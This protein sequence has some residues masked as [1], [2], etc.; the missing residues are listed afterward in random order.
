M[1]VKISRAKERLMKGVKIGEMKRGKYV[2][3]EESKREREGET[4]REGVGVGVG[5]IGRKKHN[6]REA[7]KETRERDIE[8]EGILPLE[9][10][11]VAG[12]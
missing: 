5:E 2:R 6:H 10:Y 3:N 11:E 9:T 8:G 12:S 4:A 1:K 7:V